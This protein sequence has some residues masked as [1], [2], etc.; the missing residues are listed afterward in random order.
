[1]PMLLSAG[2]KKV[3]TTGDEGPLRGT[4]PIAAAKKRKLGTAADG[5]RASDRFA[6]DLLETCGFLGRR[7]LRPSSGN[8]PREC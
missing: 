7:C 1:M 3:V 6:A 2:K 5:S 4:A 8:L